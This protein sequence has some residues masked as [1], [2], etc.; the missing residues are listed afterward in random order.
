MTTASGK[1]QQAIR[2]RGQRGGFVLGAI[3]GVLLGLAIALGVALYIA[4]VPVPFVDKVGHRT[5]EQDAAEAERL[6]TWDPNAGLAGKTQP[7]RPAASAPAAVSE[8]A[9]PVQPAPAPVLTPPVVA[10]A[11]APAKPASRP[12]VASAPTATAP[13]AP[14]ASRP[15]RDPAAILAGQDSSKPT[16]AKADP[17]GVFFVQAGAFSNPDDAEQQRAK[18]ALQGQSARVHER[19]QSGRTVYRVRIGPFDRREEAEQ[20]QEKLKESGTEAALVRADKPKN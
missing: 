8:T 11:S 16:A 6:R 7:P 18:L 14:A 9:A 20:L 12:V 4:K 17:T 1:R 15:S 13:A 5:P 10:A 2:G 19:E 3:V